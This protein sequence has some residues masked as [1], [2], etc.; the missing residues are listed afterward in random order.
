MRALSLTQPWAQAI[1]DGKKRWETRSWPTNYRGEI[2]IHASKGFPR[3]AKDFAEENGYA[4]W[5]K[6]P[7]GVIVC[8]CE[9]AA[10]C[11]T[12][13]GLLHQLTAQELSWGDYSP[14]RFA[15]RLGNVRVLPVPV[16]CTGALSIW[17]TDLETHKRIQEQITGAMEVRV[18]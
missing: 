13:E 11:A 3:W 8:V 4:A 5:A 2:A 14:G 12:T 1:C 7:A 17:S 6:L 16:P 15:F 18:L 9:I 10:C